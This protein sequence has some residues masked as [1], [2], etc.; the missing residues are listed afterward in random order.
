MQFTNLFTYLRRKNVRRVAAA[1][2]LLFIVLTPVQDVLSTPIVSVA[3]AEGAEAGKDT[4]CS[5]ESTCLSHIV[6]IFAVYIPTN[7]AY[8]AGYLFNAALL[9]ALNSTSYALDFLSIGWTVVRDIAN[10]SFIFILIYIAY[11]IIMRAETSGTMKMLAGV[12]TMALLINFSFFIT[13][14]VIDAGNILSVQFYN[15]IDTPRSVRSPLSKQN[16]PPDCVKDLTAGVMDAVKVHGLLGSDSF[17]AFIAKPGN[18][19]GTFFQNFLVQTLVFISTGIFISLLGFVFLIVGIKFIVRVVVLWL[20]IVASPLAFAA[21]AVPN[22]KTAKEY[23]KMWQDNLIQSSFYPAVFLF[24]F[25]IMT[26]FLKALA[27]DTG[28]LPN[29]FDAVA[30]INDPNTSTS[31]AGISIIAN[32]GV[33][34]GVVIVLLYFAMRA[35]DAVS[36]VGSDLANGITSWTGNRIAGASS[37]AARNTAGRA[38]NTAA[39]SAIVRD[40]AAKNP[41]LGGRLASRALNGIAT[42]SLDARGIGGLRNLAGKAGVDLTGPTNKGGYRKSEADKAHDAEKFA[43]GLKSDAVYIKKNALGVGK[44]DQERIKREGLAAAIREYQKEY[45]AKRKP[46]E[47]AF[48]ERMQGLE[49]ARVEAERAADAFKAA[50]NKTEEA[51]AQSALAANNR[52]IAELQAASAKKY[53]DAEKALAE[54]AARGESETLSKIGKEK[55]KKMDEARI[56]K[57]A[58][59][60]ESRRLGNMF[61]PSVGNIEGAEHMRHVMH[62]KSKKEKLKEL[63][64]EVAAEE[65]RGTAGEHGPEEHGPTPP[66]KPTGG[67][68]KPTPPSGGDHD[69]HH[70]LRQQTKTSTQRTIGLQGSTQALHDEIFSEEMLQRLNARVKNIDSNTSEQNTKFGD[71]QQSIN[72]VSESIE[73][74]QK[75]S[76]TAFQTGPGNRGTL[77]P[78]TDETL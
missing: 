3:H 33:R 30:K 20:A 73:R 22:N 25:F 15:A 45:D 10:L 51:K 58:D 62:E 69:N 11:T 40:W 8:V 35:S 57:V 23:Y 52:Q 27:G 21:R 74:Q 39:R 29:I 9:L 54:L 44:A 60:E 53:T 64:A 67:G 6:Y 48:H 2:L 63:A 59:Y 56:N 5:N 61:M 46:G 16:C 7:F 49:R 43:K 77:R 1:I 14:A 41:L 34:L 72:T 66:K 70:N 47:Q 19:V 28:L 55:I 37:W 17:K 4:W 71:M 31:E 65:A 24:L 32:I 76:P 42:S 75:T 12:I 13:R 26:F 36:S 38:A 18:S 68:P 78:K 50:G